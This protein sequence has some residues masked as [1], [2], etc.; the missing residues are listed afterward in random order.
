MDYYSVRPD[1]IEKTAKRLTFAMDLLV[2]ADTKGDFD[3][4]MAMCDIVNWQMRETLANK[5]GVNPE[6]AAVGL[7]EYNLWTSLAKKCKNEKTVYADRMGR[8]VVVDLWVRTRS[9]KLGKKKNTKKIVE[10]IG[11]IFDRA[12][13]I[14]NKATFMDID[15]LAFKKTD[16]NYI[17]MRGPVLKDKKLPPSIYKNLDID[18]KELEDFKATED[19]LKILD[20]SKKVLEAISFKHRGNLRDPTEVYEEVYKKWISA[21][22]GFYNAKK[23]IEK[24]NILI[25]PTLDY[26]KLLEGLMDYCIFKDLEIERPKGPYAT[27]K[28]SE[29]FVENY[30][31]WRLAQGLYAMGRRINW[32]FDR[33]NKL[34]VVI[35]MM[36]VF[37][38]LCEETTLFHDHFGVV[39]YFQ[40]LSKKDQIKLSTN[41]NAKQKHILRIFNFITLHMFRMPHVPVVDKI[42]GHRDSDSEEE[43]EKDNYCEEE[44]TKD[45]EEEKMGI[46][47]GG[48]EES[49]DNQ[50]EDEED[51]QRSKFDPE[52]RKENQERKEKFVINRPDARVLID[53]YE[54]LE[55]DLKSKNCS[56]FKKRW[57]QVTDKEEEEFNELLE[58]FGVLT[59]EGF[60]NEIYEGGVKEDFAEG[61][62]DVFKHYLRPFDD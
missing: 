4:A 50:E 57:Y 10:I 43:T 51:L 29:Y 2:E 37:C 5:D 13:I 48:K 21:V 41:L 31:R 62:A 38:V 20:E 3:T 58:D 45:K 18:K 1:L 25:V 47:C 42:D 6:E 9:S 22:F 54:R 55:E 14:R 30:L 52:K 53:I 27:V 28:D 12:V 19:F 49:Q 32:D 61:L 24:L 46:A 15:N 34:M 39:K 8:E 40:K 59:N 56:I 36:Q 23:G 60:V 17:T 11:G 33:E 26:S 7:Y 16:T 44:K 35:T